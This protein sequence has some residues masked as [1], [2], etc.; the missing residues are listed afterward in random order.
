MISLLFKIMLAIYIAS[1]LALATYVLAT[2]SSTKTPFH[3]NWLFKALVVSAIQYILTFLSI[4][5]S[6][7]VSLINKYTAIISSYYF[8]LWS[9]R[10]FTFKN[11]SHE[12]ALILAVHIF[13]YLIILL[14]CYSFFTLPR[15]VYGYYPKIVGVMTLLDPII[16]GLYSAL[17]ILVLGLQ[18]SFKNLSKQANCI[19]LFLI[20]SFSLHFLRNL[21]QTDSY[22]FSF[23]HYALRA[24]GFLVIA[25][26]IV[27]KKGR[28]LNE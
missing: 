25:N 21:L 8:F 22:I 7:V 17:T 27:C 18:V 15:N 14:S 13:E 4:D 28:Y 1:M 5:D 3:L 12:K 24:G 11:L 16:I 26:F 19:L 6:E 2:I 20:G 23:L 10:F 9:T